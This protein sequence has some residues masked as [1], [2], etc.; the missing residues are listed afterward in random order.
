[1]AFV[2]DLTVFCA[3]FGI[4]A[5]LAGVAVTAIVDTQSLIEVDGVITQQPSALVVS[6]AATSAVPG[7]VFVASSVSYTV[8]QVMKEPPDGAF[9]RLVLARV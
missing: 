8:R 6:S 1:M 5:T 4:A 9:T 7:Q 2:E 3:D